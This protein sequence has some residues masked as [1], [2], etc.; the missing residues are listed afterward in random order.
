MRAKVLAIAS[1][2]DHRL[3]RILGIGNAR[4]VIFLR[5]AWRLVERGHSVFVVSDRFGEQPVEL[6]GLVGF[7]IRRLEPLCDC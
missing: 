2:L 5:W 4:S 1:L 7:D 6:A 3:L